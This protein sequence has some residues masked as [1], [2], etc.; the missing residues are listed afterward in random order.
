LDRGEVFVVLELISDVVVIDLAVEVLLLWLISYVVVLDGGEVC[1][2]VE[3]I[4]DLVL[5]KDEDLADDQVVEGVVVVAVV[6][7]VV[8]A[9][10]YELKIFFVVFVVVIVNVIV[11]DAVVIEL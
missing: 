8:I 11:D 9:D 3:L 4:S 2:V 5:V 7:L 6:G 10:E 1:V